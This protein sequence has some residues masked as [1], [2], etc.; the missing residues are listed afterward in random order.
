MELSFE[1]ESPRTDQNPYVGP[2]RTGVPGTVFRVLD[3]PERLARAVRQ[4]MSWRGLE[5]EA[6][7]ERAGLPEGTVL[8]LARQGRGD[9]DDA[10]AVLRALGVRPVQMPAPRDM[11]GEEG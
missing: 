4:M 6:V 2:G 7:A 3:T 5:A 9:V 10:M 1:L 11:K 8:S